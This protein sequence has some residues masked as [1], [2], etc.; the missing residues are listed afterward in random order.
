MLSLFAQALH[1]SW[2]KSLGSKDTALWKKLP[3]MINDNANYF[4]QTQMDAAI[5]ILSEMVEILQK[6]LFRHENGQ[7]WSFLGPVGHFQCDFC[8]V[9]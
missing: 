6:K 8:A 7:K 1:S 5:T 2:G 9:E 4:C 3:Q